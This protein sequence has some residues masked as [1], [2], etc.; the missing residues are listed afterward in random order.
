M[1]LD[2]LVYWDA[3]V[4]VDYFNATPGRCEAIGT[5]LEQMEGDGHGKIVTS[6]V[7]KV[8]AA[9]VAAERSSNTLDDTVLDQ[10]DQMWHETPAVSLVEFHDDIAVAA[11]N[12]I[13]H[14]IMNGWSLTPVDAIHLAT[15]KWLAVQE[16]HTY[17]KGL[18]KYAA[19]VGFL[20]C[21]PYVRQNKLPTF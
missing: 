12:L 10:I 1:P 9:F 4:F 3:C 14:A 8:E 16:F 11:R 6:T 7:T 20:I 18:S 19:L 5:I 15:A 2:R 13:R 21:E 17:N